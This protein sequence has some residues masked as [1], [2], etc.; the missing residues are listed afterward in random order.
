MKTLIYSI[1]F[2]GL[3]CT[4]NYAQSNEDI[5]IKKMVQEQIDEAQK[6]MT[7][8]QEKSTVETSMDSSMFVSRLM[9]LGVFSGFLGLVFFGKR[10]YQDYKK[11]K[12]AE[13]KKSVY[14]IRKERIKPREDEKLR[15]IRK[16]LS[17]SPYS[18]RAK[19]K[20]VT[21]LAKMLK[22]TQGEI[23]LAAKINKRNGHSVLT[24]TNDDILYS[25]RNA[26]KSN[27]SSYLFNQ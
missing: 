1:L 23:Q 15:F 27:F 4:A 19:G 8:V 24:N 5:D 22:I 25:N 17:K 14:I 13:M 3:L 9:Y 10:K 16:K 6:K 26:I 18:T 20:D 21:K 7:P 11:R 2:L 12:K